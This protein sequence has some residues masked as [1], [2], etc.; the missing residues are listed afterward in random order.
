MYKIIPYEN[1]KTICNSILGQKSPI[2]FEKKA[3]LAMYFSELLSM[4]F[5]EIEHILDSMTREMMYQILYLDK[6]FVE[7]IYTKFSQYQ[8]EEIMR[9]MFNYMITVK[10]VN[11]NM[12]LLKSDEKPTIAQ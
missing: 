1:I 6:Q 7:N 3:L 2:P 10:E 5:Y 9:D 11:R 8:L 4:S 12:E